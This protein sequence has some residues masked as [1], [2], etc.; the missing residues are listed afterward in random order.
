MMCFRKYPVA[1]KFMDKTGMGW[2]TK[3]SV[4][5]FMTQ[6][7]KFLQVKPLVFHYFRVSKNVWEKRSWWGD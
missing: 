1:K 3:F 7:R 5:V 6:C 2:V 4:E